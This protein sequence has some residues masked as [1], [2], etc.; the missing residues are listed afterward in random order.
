MDNHYYSE[1]VTI[2][3]RVSTCK[4]EILKKNYKLHLKSVHPKENCEDLTPY[5]Q[6]KIS[7]LFSNKP[8][9]KSVGQTDDD[10]E[11]EPPGLVDFDDEKVIVQEGKKRHWSGDSGLGDESCSTSKKSRGRD[12]LDDSNGAVTHKDL[13][14]KLDQIL[15]AV[16][17]EK[18][19]AKDAISVQDQEKGDSSELVKKIKYCRSMKVILDSGFS[20]DSE[21]EILS[22]SVCED[23]VASGEF[24]YSPEEGLEFKEDEFLPREFINLKRT[25]CRH[26]QQSKSHTEAVKT[27]AEKGDEANR[28]KSKT[29]QAG[30]NL[31]RACMQGYLLGRPFTD[32][33]SNIL[34]LKMSGAEV[35]ELNHSRKF[36]PA[37]RSSVSKVVN[38]RVKK[39]IQTPLEQTGHMPPVCI[40]ADKGTYKHR[41]RQFLSVVTIMPGGQSLSAGSHYLWTA[42][43]Y[44][45]QHREGTCQEY[46]EWV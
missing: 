7:D 10:H 42:S 35:G 6:S 1:T 41:G 18:L 37:F 46:E 31:G 12:I 36:P 44:R 17:G 9:K 26:I 5:G 38:R 21:S 25:V 11:K 4:K 19:Q 20:Y 27:Q 24:L 39:F 15:L 14:E 30:M 16:K 43:C 2:K 28:L 8:K 29:Y 34:L 22:C 40:S 33:E 32:Y 23:S 3:C 45:W 13:D